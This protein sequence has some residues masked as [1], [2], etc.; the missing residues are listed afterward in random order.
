MAVKTFTTGE[1]LT[2]ADTNT[3]LN[4]GG[5]VYIKSQTIGSAVSLVTVSSA[6]SSDYDAYKII[7]AGGAASGTTYLNFRVGTSG[8]PDTGSVYQQSFLHTTFTN[9]AAAVGNT[10]TVVTY[11]GSADANGLLAGVDV[12][13]PN[14][15]SKTIVSAFAAAQGSFSGQTTALVNTNTQYTHF[16]IYTNA[17]TMTGGTITVYGYRKA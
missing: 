11:A 9:T 2:A 16:T 10:G 14:L 8:G 15:A 4:N 7:V 1:V 12:Y 17:G 6:F 13:S 5:L 3:Y